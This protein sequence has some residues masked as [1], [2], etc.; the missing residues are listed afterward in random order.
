MTSVKQWPITYWVNTQVTTNLLM[1]TAVNTSASQG[2]D[3]ILHVFLPERAHQTRGTYSRASR[4]PVQ[5]EA[6]SL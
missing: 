1:A 5:F 3:Q 2:A 6:G 4:T